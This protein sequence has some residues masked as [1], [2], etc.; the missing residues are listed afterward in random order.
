MFSFRNGLTLGSEEHCWNHNERTD[1]G[2]AEAAET[3]IK[4]ELEKSR[5]SLGIHDYALAAMN[6]W[7]RLTIIATLLSY[8]NWCLVSG[9]QR[10]NCSFAS[11]LEL[12]NNLAMNVD[13]QCR[14]Q[15]CMST[16]CRQMIDVDD[17]DSRVWR[18]VRHALRV[19]T[20]RYATATAGHVNLLTACRYD[21]L[22]TIA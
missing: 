2:A 15:S 1:F 11:T 3:D 13:C 8:K 20:T 17:E 18:T 19:L 14:Q 16:D 5:N 21:P 7:K 6:W 12:D 10:V 4:P 9:L 22:L